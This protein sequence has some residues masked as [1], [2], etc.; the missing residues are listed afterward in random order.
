VAGRVVASLAIDDG[1]PATTPLWL[2]SQGPSPNGAA[3]VSTTGMPA[4][5]L[6]T[7]AST[8]PAR[9]TRASAGSVASLHRGVARR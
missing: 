5:A 6:R 4:V 9:V 7:A 1:Q 8:A 2:N 3:A